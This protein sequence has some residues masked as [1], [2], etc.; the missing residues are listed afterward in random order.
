M[1]WGQSGK[2]CQYC[3]QVLGVVLASRQRASVSSALVSV[4]A[5]TFA[6][7]SAV[8]MARTASAHWRGSSCRRR[9][10]AHVDVS[11]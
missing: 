11:T 3:K 1:L 8:P 6:L 9:V 10:G 2:R 5:A 4:P 7:A